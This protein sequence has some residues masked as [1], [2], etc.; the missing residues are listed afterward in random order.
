MNTRSSSSVEPGEMY[1]P[2]GWANRLTSGGGNCS[3]GSGHSPATTTVVTGAAPSAV[4][5]SATRTSMLPLLALKYDNTV[6][7]STWRML[8]SPIR[9]GHSGVGVL[10][11]PPSDDQPCQL[12]RSVKVSR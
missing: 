5:L 3:A 4:G 1:P 7:P 12:A 11:Q 6:F 9:S 10:P 8:I 2:Y